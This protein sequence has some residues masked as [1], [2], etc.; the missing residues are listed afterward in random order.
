MTKGGKFSG[1][2]LTASMLVLWAVLSMASAANAGMTPPPAAQALTPAQAARTVCA[3]DPRLG[4]RL[5]AAGVRTNAVYL[6]EY[7]RSALAASFNG[8]GCGVLFTGTTQVPDRDL[9]D[10]VVQRLVAMN[11]QEF[12]MPL[13][14]P[15]KLSFAA[16]RGLCRVDNQRLGQLGKPQADLQAAVTA[17]KSKLGC[18]SPIPQDVLIAEFVGPDVPDMTDT[19][20]AALGPAGPAPKTSTQ[21]SDPAVAE[22]KRTVCILDMAEVDRTVARSYPA[23]TKTATYDAWLTLAAVETFNA[24]NCGVAGYGL[25][26]FPNLV[27]DVTR[28]LLQVDPKSAPP[29]KPAVKFAANRGLCIFDMTVLQGAPKDALAGAKTKRGCAVLLPAHVLYPGLI[30]PDIPDITKDIVASGRR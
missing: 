15:P 11:V 25:T 16:N 21:D 2:P 30:G 6:S 17:A 27:N 14:A 22:A 12:G 1:G 5:Q 7:M 8:R 26:G 29:A 20:I 3:I 18:V 28:R 24:H 4:A 10:D 9:T 13:E 23:L 19:V